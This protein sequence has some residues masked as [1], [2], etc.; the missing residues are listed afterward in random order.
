MLRYCI[1]ALLEDSHSSTT[2]QVYQQG[3]L[4]PTLWM[5]MA[6]ASISGICTRLASTLQPHQHKHQ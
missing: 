2:A 6:Q 5:E 1:C 4:S 3:N